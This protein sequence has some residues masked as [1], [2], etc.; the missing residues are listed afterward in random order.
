MHGTESRGEKVAGARTAD[1]L[2]FS[3]L[4]SE[5]VLRHCRFSYEYTPQIRNHMVLSLASLA[6]AAVLVSADHILMRS[7]RVVYIAILWL[8]SHIPM[9]SIFKLPLTFQP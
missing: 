7:F 5:L 8:R 3:V 6:T 2:D 1:G 4:C 9:S